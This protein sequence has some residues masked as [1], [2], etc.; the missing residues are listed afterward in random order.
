MARVDCTP[1]VWWVVEC[2]LT[3]IVPLPPSAHMRAASRILSAGTE[4]YASAH[5]GV[6]SLR[7]SLKA[8]NAG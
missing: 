2:G 8:W 7:D 6:K 1:L 5:S 3:H 4:L